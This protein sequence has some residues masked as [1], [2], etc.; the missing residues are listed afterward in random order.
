[1]D[2][3]TDRAGHSRVHWPET[4]CK[5]WKFLSSFYARSL[6]HLVTDLQ[7]KTKPITKQPSEKKKTTT[8]WQHPSVKIRDYSTCISLESLVQWIS[9]TSVTVGLQVF[10]HDFFIFGYAKVRFLMGNPSSE[11]PSPLGLGDKDLSK[12]IVYKPRSFSTKGWK[13]NEKIDLFRSIK[14]MIYTKNT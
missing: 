12:N 2:Q 5:P 7:K 4:Y 14:S 9:A 13:E 1:M 8:S 6:F 11:H 10:C 3:P